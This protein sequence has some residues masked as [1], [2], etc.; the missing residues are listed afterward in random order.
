MDHISFNSIYMRFGAGLQ[1]W[2]ESRM[3]LYASRDGSLLA[4]RNEA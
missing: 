3:R 4:L 1:A 2:V